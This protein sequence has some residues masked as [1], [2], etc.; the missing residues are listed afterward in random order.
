MRT[1][2]DARISA[3]EV[4]TGPYDRSIPTVLLTLSGVDKAQ[5]Y[6][7][8]HQGE[9]WTQRTGERLDQLQARALAGASLHPPSK[10]GRFPV[11]VLCAKPLQPWHAPTRTMS[12][13]AD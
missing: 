13:A 8:L 7:I 4:A 9:T 3:L 10:G 11:L 6:A 12:G 2:L 1:T 5:P